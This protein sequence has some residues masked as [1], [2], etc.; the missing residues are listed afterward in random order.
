MGVDHGGE[1]VVRIQWVR[2]LGCGVVYV[3]PQ[4]GGTI[5]TNPGCPHCG[6]LGWVKDSSTVRR[7]PLHRRS[8]ADRPQRRT[9]WRG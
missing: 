5:S 2:C 7:T 8:V 1:P 9:G 4:A 6:Y 3:Q